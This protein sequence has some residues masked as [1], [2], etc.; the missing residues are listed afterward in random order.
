M[1]FPAESDSALVPLFPLP[2]CVLFPG[3]VLPLHVFEPRYRAMMHDVL[4]ETS[5]RRYIALA[6]LKQNAEEFYSTKVAPIYNTVCLGRILES[7][8]RP[9]GTYNLLLLGTLRAS[10]LAED[11]SRPYRRAQ[12]VVVRTRDDIVADDNQDIIAMIRSHLIQL[13]SQWPASRAV[14]EK[15]IEG[16][17]NF[18]TLV[19]LLTYHLLPAEDCLL[20]QRVLEEPLLSA[21]AQ[22]L[23]RWLS[24][25]LR[26]GRRFAAGSKVPL[27]STLGL[28]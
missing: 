24:T 1:G 23:T 15:L 2:R 19:D 14:F 13:E 21:R 4:N 8:Q 7:Q 20:K 28:N 11:L 22:I 12:L 26:S 17:A 16:G 25:A 5:G 6:L 27:S 18:T 9:D 3:V 10:I